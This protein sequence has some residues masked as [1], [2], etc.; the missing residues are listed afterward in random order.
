MKLK[1]YRSTAFALMISFVVSACSSMSSI[2]TVDRLEL[3]RFMGDWYVIA[4]IPT[5]LE[6]KAYNAVERY[7]LDDNGTVATT[8]TFRKGGFD[9]PLKTYRPRGFVHDD[10]NAVWGMRFLWPFKADYRIIYLESDYSIAVVGRSKRD[11]LWVM[12]RGTVIPET[13]LREILEYTE[14]LGYD[15]SQVRMVPQKW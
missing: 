2:K 8:F 14:S 12:A 13:R 6:K 10:S 5:A 11:Y 9:G 15:L 7:H 3:E 1:K 4:N